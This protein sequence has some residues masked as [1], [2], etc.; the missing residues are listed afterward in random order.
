MIDLTV[1]PAG[2]ALINV[3]AKCGLHYMRKNNIPVTD[4]GFHQMVH[5][6]KESGA[7]GGIV[8]QG[9]ENDPQVQQELKAI[10]EMATYEDAD[11]LR[12]VTERG[13]CQR[14]RVWQRIKELA[15]EYSESSI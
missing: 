11:L 5:I 13:I 7:N 2:R 15:Q 14:L 8:F 3:M 1:T 4:D 6:S 12:Q 10:E 9:L